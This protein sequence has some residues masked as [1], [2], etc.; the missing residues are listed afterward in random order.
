MVLAAIGPLS[1]LSRR[2]G[3]SWA[4]LGEGLG[5]ILG[6]FVEVAF[7]AVRHGIAP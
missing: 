6:G 2:I 4:A 5:M 7:A 3:F 1:R